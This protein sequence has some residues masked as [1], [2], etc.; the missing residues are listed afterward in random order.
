MIAFVIAEVIPFFEDLLSL[1]SA[2]F[3]SG[4]TFYIPALM[5]FILIRKGSWTSPRNLALGA[6]NLAVLVM[7]L[8]ILAGGTYASIQDIVSCR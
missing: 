5:W 6:L 1:I 3:I 7:G 8:V 4:F 2:L